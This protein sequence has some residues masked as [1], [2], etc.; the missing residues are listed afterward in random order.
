[1]AGQDATIE[2][3]E[4]PA[5]RRRRRPNSVEVREQIL[6]V[7][8]QR[9]KL[10]R[11]HGTHEFVPNVIN[12][13]IEG[14]NYVD[15][16]SSESEPSLKVR[17]ELR[18]QVVR[19]FNARPVAS[20]VE[21]RQQRLGIAEALRFARDERRLDEHRAGVVPDPTE[22]GAQ[23]GDAQNALRPLIDHADIAPIS[24]DA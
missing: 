5:S 18:R 15:D 6:G 9:S 8:S 2:R 3:A 23:R 19:N 11:Q 1:M 21:K 7:D 16:S 12:G 17:R 22:P 13:P 24:G 20:S 4:H 10:T 14:V